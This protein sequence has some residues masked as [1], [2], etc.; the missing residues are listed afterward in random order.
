MQ[1]RRPHNGTFDGQGRLV[2]GDSFNHLIRRWD[3]ASDQVVTLAGSAVEG[4][5]EV[6]QL[7]RSAD[8]N[9]IGAIVVEPSGGVVF[10]SVTD[11]RVWRIRSDDG[12]LEIVAGTGEEGLSG[13]GGP[14]TEARLAFPY[15]LALGPD[16]RLYVADSGNRRIRVVDLASGRIKTIAGG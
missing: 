1:L 14:A 12:R 7:A 10:T 15:G 8:L 6:G 13:D 11:N 16:D 9:Y 4:V 5:P 2:F 3:P